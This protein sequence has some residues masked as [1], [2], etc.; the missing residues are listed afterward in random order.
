MASHACTQMASHACAPARHACSTAFR[1]RTQAR[2]PADLHAPCT[3]APSRTM[4]LC[5]AYACAFTKASFAPPSFF[6][7]KLGIWLGSPSSSQ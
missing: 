6:L 2:L 5:R 3:C 7:V 4:T 1:A